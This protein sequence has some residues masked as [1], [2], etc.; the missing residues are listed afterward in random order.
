M[1]RYLPVLLLFLCTLANA[2]GNRELSIK[3]NY[4]FNAATPLELNF[5]DYTTA[6]GAQLRFNT[7]NFYVSNIRLVPTV[8]NEV[9]LDTVLLIMETTAGTTFDIGQL[10]TGSYESLMFDIGLDSAR[11][12]GDPT[13]YGVNHPLAYTNMFW[14][15]NS[16]YIFFKIE[17]EVDTTASQSGSLVPFGYHVGSD[18]LSKTIALPINLEV[19]SNT[20][21]ILADVDFRLASLISTLQ[22]KG[23]SPDLSTHT[24]DNMP[25]ATELAN[26]L[27]S[28][29]STEVTKQDVSGIS[30]LEAA[31]VISLSPNPM[32]NT[33]EIAVKA[34]QATMVEVFDLSG[35]KL[36][37]Q[38]LTNGATTMFHNQFPA[39]GIYFV[40]VKGTSQVRKLVVQ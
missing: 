29:F 31:K 38:T 10:P 15:W 12:H 37:A 11:N 36:F 39:A 8:G 14:S 1:K 5:T 35:K 28:S 3:F 19:T 23:S 24:F 6:D 7:A 21:H 34:P 16:G 22:L 32:Q 4:F 9:V 25:L 18:A 33:T 20:E 13:T 27:Q 40:K 30:D 2:Q 17:G 26:N